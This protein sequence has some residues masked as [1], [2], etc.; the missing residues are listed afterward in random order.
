MD[1]AFIITWKAPYP[2]REAG[3]LELAVE[4]NEYWGKLAADGKCTPPEWFF[5]PT[6]TGMWIVKGD[7]RVLEE[8]VET[9]E[10]RRLITKGT[11]LL[12]DWQWC[13]ARTGGAAEQFIGEYAAAAQAAG[14]I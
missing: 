14:I 10:A 6:G 4:S 5:L 3:A 8:L 1:T 13:L 7:R 2:G 9:D 12:D 11:L